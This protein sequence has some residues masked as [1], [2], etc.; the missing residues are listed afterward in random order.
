MR[1]SYSELKYQF[2]QHYQLIN[3]PETVEKS[4]SLNEADTAIVNTSVITNI[5]DSESSMLPDLDFSIEN[6]SESI[7]ILKLCI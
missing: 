5:S 2:R 4:S 3:S 7:Y 6:N 1:L